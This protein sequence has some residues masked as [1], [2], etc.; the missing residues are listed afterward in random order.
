MIANIIDVAETKNFIHIMME[1]AEGGDFEEYLSS[2]GPLNEEKAR[3]CFL[4]MVTAV[5]YLHHEGIAKNNLKYQKIRISKR[6][7]PELLQDI[8]T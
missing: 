6:L 5:A 3:R 4:Q 7:Q 8:C 1:L 2:Q